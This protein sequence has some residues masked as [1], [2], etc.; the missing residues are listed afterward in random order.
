MKNILKEMDM[1]TKRLLFCAGIILVLSG[2]TAGSGREAGNIGSIDSGKKEIIVNLKSGINLRMGELLEI[3]TAGG[4]IV[5]E[6]TYPM[7]TV[8]RCKIKG[9][10]RLA[11]L[12]KGMKV[13]MYS[14]SSG[15]DAAAAD[16][17]K[18]EKH[19]EM[20]LVL[21][22]GGT[23]IMGS[24]DSIDPYGNEDMHSV[25]LNSF[26]IGKYEV[27]Q[28]QYVEIMGPD[29]STVKGDKLPVEK[30]SWYEAVEYCN[31]LS[32]KYKMKRYYGINKN[33]ADAA[34]KNTREKIKYTVTI[35]GGTGFRLPT[36]AE[37]EYACRAGTTTFFCYGDSLD[38]TMANFDGFMPYNAAKG[39]RSTRVVEVGS[40]KS[41][42]W[43]LY[44]MHGNVMEWCWDWYDEGYYKKSP[45]KNPK[46]AAG[47]V[48]RVMRGGAW[49]N[50]A[51]ILRSAYRLPVPSSAHFDGQGFRVV[52]SAD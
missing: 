36:E 10:G 48:D 35:I 8:A 33:K 49:H 43:G 26:Y 9:K 22:H 51:N 42:A 25:T 20:E 3:D 1:K 23:F 18:T 29:R 50:G 17:N 41:N 45:A 38:S 6:V 13:R 37:W 32:D 15:D 7:Q 46:G 40:F 12:E 30:V 39:I 21:I 24:P 28:K 5:L 52:R 31:K 19:G 44:D 11:D 2:I 4:R 47:G 34:N 16:K 27:T 14:G